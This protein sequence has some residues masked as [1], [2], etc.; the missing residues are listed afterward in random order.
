M[1]IT[2]VISLLF[3]SVGTV[4]LTSG[5]SA[6]LTHP[7]AP[8]NRVFFA[9]TAAITIWSAGMAFSTIASDAETCEFFR[10]FSAIGWSTAY[11]FLLHFILIKTG[12]SLSLK[13]WWFYLCLYLPSFFS[14]LAFAVPNII[15]P[16]LYNL[17]RT[18]YGWINA[19]YNNIWDLIFYSYYIGFTLTGL[20]LLYKWGKKSSAR[21]KYY[22]SV[23]KQAP[24]GIAIMNDKRHSRNE[25]FSDININPVYARILGR[26]KEELQ[27][28]TW[29]EISFPED[30]DIDLVYYEKF[31]KGEIDQYSIEKRFFKPD[32]SIVW[33]NMLISPFNT[34]EGKSDEHVCIITD[35][36]KRKE[37]EATLKYNNEHVMLTGLYNRN[38]LEKKLELDA[39][40]NPTDKRAL[41]GINLA[42]MHILSL[43]YGFNY[44]QDMLKKIADSLK[45]LCNDDNNTLFNTYENQ[46][47]FYIK[48][49]KE[50]KELTAFCEAVSVA[51]NSHLYIHGILC[52]IG[53]IEI[54]ISHMNSTDELLKMLLITSDMATKKHSRGSIISFYGPEIKAQAIRENDISRELT[55]ITEGINSDRLFLQYQPIFDI[56]SNRVC[57]FEALARLNSEKYGLVSPLEFISIAEKSNM[58]VSVGEKI[59]HQAFNFLVKL[60]ENGHETITL[61]VNVST[62]QMLDK[63]FANRLLNLARNMRIN[64]ENIGIELT[65]SIFATEWSEINTVIAKFKSYGIKILMDD[66]G[67]GYSSFARERE[68]NINYIK[69]DKSFID[70]LL[71]LRSGEAIT[72]DIISM[73]HKLGHCVV[74][75]GVEHEKQLSYLRDH[76]CDRIQG[77]LISKPVDEEEAMDWVNKKEINNDFYSSYSQH[78]EMVR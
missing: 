51:L 30:L 54:N 65:E 32:G 38:E 39:L 46:F 57:G 68:L 64:P 37:I 31:K 63:G 53:V 62:I 40:M 14:L 1:L 25:D 21:E 75:E 67:T 41:V 47:V 26:T 10:R 74:A 2:W 58:I 55:E 4:V 42:A 52:G 70:R 35:I 72:G 12:K 17:Q 34:S 24:V 8:A 20:F 16:N 50:K 43:R 36:T 73:A 29:E 3:F 6:L 27:N 13:K 23:F 61:S 56:K 59:I 18:A 45:V 9:L 44:S 28:I 15:N 7:K 77:Y 66:F 33:V 22:S 71:V 5:I 76:G 49:Y 19:A 48:G 60:K 78:Q 11:A 69:I